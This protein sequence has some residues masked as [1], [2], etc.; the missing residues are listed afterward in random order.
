MNLEFLLLFLGLGLIAVIANAMSA[1]GGGAGLVQLPALILLGLLATAL[2]THKLAS[3]ACIGCRWA[4][5]A[6]QQSR[7]A[8]VQPCVAGGLAR[9]LDR[10]QC[11]PSPPD[12]WPRPPSDC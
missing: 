2:A 8:S 5:L 3:V 1:M 10:R 6:S 9:S 7:S 12:R 11:S 4:S